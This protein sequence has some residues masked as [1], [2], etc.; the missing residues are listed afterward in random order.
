MNAVRLKKEREKEQ[1]PR[2]FCI[3][4][5]SEWKKKCFLQC[6]PFIVPQSLL[7]SFLLSKCSHV[8]QP[9]QARKEKGGIDLSVAKAA[10]RITAA[11]QCHWQP[12]PARVGSGYVNNLAQQKASGQS[13]SGWAAPVEYWTVG[14][15]RERK[16][17][18]GKERS[19]WLCKTK[20]KKRATQDPRLTCWRIADWWKRTTIPGK[21]VVSEH[22]NNSC[23]FFSTGSV[24]LRQHHPT[25]LKLT[26]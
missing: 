13:G 1:N 12:A 2:T 3:P 15:E 22:K 14:G 20:R 17:E 5:F 4:G 9:P 10:L 7:F 26:F 24:R 8:A 6:P 21:D 23:T 11:L 25:S 19:A 16:K 18:R